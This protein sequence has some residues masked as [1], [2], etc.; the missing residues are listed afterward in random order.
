MLELNKPLN[1]EAI[2]LGKNNTIEFYADKNLD[3][4]Q[5]NRLKDV[6]HYNLYTETSFHFN[7]IEGQLWI[8]VYVKGLGL[9]INES[10]S[11]NPRDKI[12]VLNFINKDNNRIKSQIEEM[13]HMLKNQN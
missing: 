9:M 12:A 3:D 4:Y 10:I 8:N 1:D 11:M 7:E 6:L 13:Q 2:Q 5:K